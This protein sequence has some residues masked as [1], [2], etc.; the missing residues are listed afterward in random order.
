MQLS[1]EWAHPCDTRE[2][3]L[4]SLLMAD[5]SFSRACE[6]GAAVVEIRAAGDDGQA[7]LLP[8]SSVVRIN[9]ASAILAHADAAKLTPNIPL[10]IIRNAL[11]FLPEVRRVLQIFFEKVAERG[12]LVIIVPHQ[13]LYERKMRLPSRLNP[14]HRRFYTSNTLLADVEEAIDPTEFRIRTLTE[15]DVGYN[16]GQELAEI[17]EGG[18][19]I[20]LI[21]ERLPRPVWRPRLDRE[22]IWAFRPPSEFASR[23]LT[24]S[25]EELD[26]VVHRI[27]RPDNES[28]QRILLTKLD[29]R[30]DFLMSN[31]AFAMIRANFPKAEITLVCG[32]WN[33]AEAEASGHFDKVVIFDFFPE[34][35]SAR[36]MKPDRDVLL[37]EFQ[38]LVV[39][40]LYDL[41]A[42]FRLYDDTRFLLEAVSARH[43]AGFDRL[44]A[45]PWMSIR[46]QVQSST[47]DQRSEQGFIRA[48]SFH[49]SIGRHRTFEIR[50]DSTARFSEQKSLIWGPYRQ[51]PAGEY[52]F[53]FFIEPLDEP[54]EL[55]FDVVNKQGT[56]TLAAGALDI[57]RH[58]H[59]RV[60]LT[61]PEQT[62][63]LELRLLSSKD[64]DVK[65]FRFSGISFRRYGRHPGLHQTEAMA[66]LAQ[67]IG[68]RLRHPF[69]TTAS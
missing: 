18:Q 3:S 5:E 64:V 54:F 50:H 61:I 39:D 12:L 53:E 20:I 4:L 45:F 44:D 13:F 59:L 11:Q 21:M 28:I 65:P 34:D 60:W 51:F 43:K 16:Y 36:Q 35:D 57:K 7:A 63:D 23:M 24:A 30:G 52:E 56:V 32:S 19:D 40:E 27:V 10:L 2:K 67:L 58:G 47:E 25:R 41:A 42:D 1:R 17:P 48:E 29:H 22:D 46:L 66:M 49:Q 14:L 6:A 55:L 15:N 69:L 26:R 8:Y 33:R 31:E 37:K 62:M 38:V 68:L 9:S